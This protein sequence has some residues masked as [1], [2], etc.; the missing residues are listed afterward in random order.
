[1][2]IE[3]IPHEQTRP[4]EKGLGQKG[5]TEPIPPADERARKIAERLGLK[6]ETVEKQF[7]KPLPNVPS[8]SN[9]IKKKLSQ[10]LGKITQ[11]C[12]E[13]V[14]QSET[15]ITKIFAKRKTQKS[16]PQWKSSIKKGV[17][18][19][20]NHIITL[21]SHRNAPQAIQSLLENLR[22]SANELEE[23]KE[24]SPGKETALKDSLE[25][26]V[27]CKAFRK[28]LVKEEDPRAGSLTEPVLQ[29]AL[30]DTI[31]TLY[32]TKEDISNALTRFRPAQTALFFSKE[33][34]SIDEKEMHRIENVIQQ[35]LTKK[36]RSQQLKEP[37]TELSTKSEDFFIEKE[38]QKTSKSAKLP[39]ASWKSR[40]KDLKP[41]IRTLLTETTA[42]IKK[43]IAY[44][45]SI[46]L[47]AF[48]K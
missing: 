15:K 11:Q 32:K 46:V 23:V 31:I 13:M 9:S 43:N 1:M 40:S 5:Q 26:L 30:A 33:D 25:K 36:E 24:G 22:K 18:T 47:K 44:I 45:Q 35:A 12:L 17:I 19:F 10:V 37:T 7:R 8:S 29:N 42:K 39:E 41:K 20:R 16:I 2:G 48:K 4:L 3:E 21:G 38:E 27:S 34:A 28:L 6:L 14:K